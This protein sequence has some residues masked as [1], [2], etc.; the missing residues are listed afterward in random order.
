ME[1][2][3]SRDVLA[4]DISGSILSDETRRD[5]VG[6]EAVPEWTLSTLVRLG[7]VMRDEIMFETAF[8]ISN[9]F[10][11]VKCEPLAALIVNGRSYARHR[12]VY[13]V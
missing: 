11:H 7:I 12:I 9:N 4:I 5:F 8:E 10:I 1:L 2:E 3:M 13:L 6:A